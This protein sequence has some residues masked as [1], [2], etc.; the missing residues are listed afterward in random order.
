M[1]CLMGV[2]CRGRAHLRDSRSDEEDGRE[3]ADNR[4]EWLDLLDGLRELGVEAHT[5]DDGY[6]HDLEG[7]H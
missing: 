5:Q 6:K 3:D 1:G 2:G 4:G 7:A